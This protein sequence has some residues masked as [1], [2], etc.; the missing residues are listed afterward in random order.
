MEERLAGYPVEPS[1]VPP[2]G[3]AESSRKGY[4]A[5]MMLSS[6]D[7]PCFAGDDDA[8]VLVAANSCR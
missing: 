2:V 6:D 4:P 8:C 1:V 7:D 5:M 3:N